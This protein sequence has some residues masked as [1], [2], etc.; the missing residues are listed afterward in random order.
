M[1]KKLSASRYVVPTMCV[2]VFILMVKKERKRY[3]R[4]ERFLLTY[5]SSF[6]PV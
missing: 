5:F 2:P 6:S 4:N 1:Q 3:A